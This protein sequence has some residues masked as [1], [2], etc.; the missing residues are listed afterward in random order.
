MKQAKTGKNKLALKFTGMCHSKRDTEERYK[1]SFLVKNMKG[2]TWNASKR[3]MAAST[4]NVIIMSNGNVTWDNRR[5]CYSS[6]EF[7]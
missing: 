6:N 2:A 7:E 5:S 1:N 3:I 4:K